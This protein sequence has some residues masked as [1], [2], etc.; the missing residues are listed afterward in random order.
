MKKQNDIFNYMH[1]HELAKVHQL[2]CISL[3]LPTYRAGEEVKQNVAPKTLKNLLKH[4]TKELESR[5]LKQH[6]I[7]KML[8]PVTGIL[9]DNKFWTEQSDGLCIFLSK[10]DFTWFKI[11]ISFDPWYYVADHYYLKPLVPMLNRNNK[12]YL[13]NLSIDNLNLFECTPYSLQLIESDELPG[14]LEDVVGY[15]KE[16]DHLQQRSGQDA[17]GSAVYHG[18]G[19]HKDSKANERRQFIHAV[20]NGLNAI[21]KDQ[22]TPLILAADEKNAGLFR[23][24]SQYKNLFKDFIALHPNGADPLLLHEFAMEKLEPLFEESKKKKIKTLLDHSNTDKTHTDIRDIVPASVNGRVDTL[25]IQKDKEEYGL[26]DKKSNSVIIDNERMPQNAA[27]YNMMA[28][29]TILNQGT[30]YL[31]DENDMPLAHTSVNALLRY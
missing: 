3:F 21:I 4:L 8:E 1:F 12:F 2:N 19:S 9:N 20:D 22:K 10:Q 26:F 30:V 18:H 29:N 24:Q 15:D 7:E 6:E 13:L 25:F 17:H 27:L 23:K 14:K 28:V 31:Q 16:P 11:P 5:E